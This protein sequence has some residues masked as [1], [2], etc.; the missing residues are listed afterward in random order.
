MLSH[1]KDTEP[2]NVRA[3]VRDYPHPSSDSSPAMQKNRVAPRAAA[4]T[5]HDDD[6]SCAALLAVR[7]FN[8]ASLTMT[9]QALAAPEATQ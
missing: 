3:E 6:S 2:S 5:Q 1:I 9:S 8:V 7:A 4:H